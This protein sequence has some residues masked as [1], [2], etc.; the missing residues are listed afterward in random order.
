MK[1]I[2][3]L[4]FQIVGAITL[5]GLVGSCVLMSFAG[6][7]LQVDDGPAKADYVLPL[8]GDN[9]RNI[10]AAE[11]FQQGWAPRLLVSMAYSYPPTKMDEIKIRMGYPQFPSLRAWYEALYTTL[12]IKLDNLEF[13]GN[14]H[15]STVEEAEALRTHL[16]AAPV[17]LLLVTSPYHARRAKTIFQDIYPEADIHMVITPYESFE[18]RWWT[19][20]YSAQMV[21]LETAKTLHYLLGGV[22]RSTDTI[23]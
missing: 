23:H 8:A 7:W 14:G 16:R 5:F 6:Q 10:Y 18:E 12:G 1:R 21:V 9:N 20:Q 22:Y 19:D 17:R 13:F 4:F 3:S 15:V 2:L 11:L